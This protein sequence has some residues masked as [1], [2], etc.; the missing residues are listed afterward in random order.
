MVKRLFVTKEHN[1]HNEI[2]QYVLRLCCEYYQEWIHVKVDSFV[3]IDLGGGAAY[4]GKP[5]VYVNPTDDSV[6]MC[7]LEK[8]IAKIQ[9]NYQQLNGGLVSEGW[10]IMAPTTQTSRTGR[11][12]K[13]AGG[14]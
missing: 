4:E 2:G 7:I 13:L 11:S 3:P 1:D 5:C 9:G 12:A 10:K 6:W 8:A 14:R